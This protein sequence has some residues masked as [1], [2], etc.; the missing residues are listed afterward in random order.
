MRVLPQELDRGDVPTDPYLNGK[1]DAVTASAANIFRRTW[2][3]RAEGTRTCQDLRWWFA[4][5]DGFDAQYPQ[6]S[7]WV[8]ILGAGR[9]VLEASERIR[10]RTL[11][12]RRAW[13]L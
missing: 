7:E 11:R 12:P 2:R 1:A 6:R 4:S 9:R 5:T 13:F 3:R 8:L 10:V